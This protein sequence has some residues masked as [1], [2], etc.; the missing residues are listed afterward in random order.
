MSLLTPMTDRR[1][2]LKPEL[3]AQ[4]EETARGENRRP[5]ES[6]EHAWRRYVEEKWRIQLIKN[7]QESA[8]RRGIQEAGTDRL[9]SNYRAGHR[10]S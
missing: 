9:I 4:V 8:K 5:S 1:E 2:I 10:S 3:I 7:G 6:L